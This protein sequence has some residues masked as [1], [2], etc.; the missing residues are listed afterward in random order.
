MGR[1]TLFF[2]LSTLMACEAGTGGKLTTVDFRLEVLA[3]PQVTLDD[4]ATVRLERATLSFGPLYVFEAPPPTARPW[5]K[6]ASELVVPTAHAHPG[7]DFFSGGRVM[8]EW[9]EPKVVDLLT[10]SHELGTV[11]AI[12]GT[13]RSMSVHLLKDDDNAK[14]ALRL[15]GTVTRGDTT[16]PF[17]LDA[18]L[19]GG[20]DDQRVD[21]VPVEWTLDEGQ[22]VIV[23]VDPRAWFRGARFE[24]TTLE[25]IA[26]DSQ[27]GRAVQVNLRRFAAWGGRTEAASRQER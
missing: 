14:Q 7:H 8:T 9:I 5:W 17:T 15:A 27:T 2:L 11:P 22:A 21:F 26:A 19:P 13:A 10:A 1:L 18:A 4:G 25:P 6:R 20:F 23:V 3:M 12:A 16:R 24:E